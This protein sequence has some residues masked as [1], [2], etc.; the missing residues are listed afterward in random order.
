M[1]R[2]FSFLMWKWDQLKKKT[3]RKTINCVWHWNMVLRP[4]TVGILT[5]A[6]L[7]LISSAGQINFSVQ[8]DNEIIWEKR[9]KLFGTVWEFLI[10][11]II[12]HYPI[13]NFSNMKWWRR[14]LY[15]RH[16]LICKRILNFFS[17]VDIGAVLQ[18]PHNS[19]YKL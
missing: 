7:G 1:G 17:I 4:E 12:F 11:I 10:V 2:N 3:W 6:T 16:S 18:N 15:W 14:K 13:P 19:Q 5:L 8:I 9:G